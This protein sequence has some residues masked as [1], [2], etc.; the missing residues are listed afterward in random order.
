[1]LMT[2]PHWSLVE[3][4]RADA[5]TTPASAASGLLLPGQHAVAVGAGGGAQLE[6][7]VEAGRPGPRHEREQFRAEF[8]GRARTGC[9]ASTGHAISAAAPATPSAP[10]VSP[11][12]SNTARSAGTPA[13]SARRCSWAASASAGCPNG[14]PSST[15]PGPP[16]LAWRSAA[17]IASQFSFTS[18]APDTLTSLNTCGCLRISLAAIPSATSSIVYPVPS[19]RSDATSA[20]KYTCSR[21]SPSSSRTASGSPLSS[22]SIAS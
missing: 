12:T 2:C 1:M 5:L 8:A 20:W 21:T 18:S 17:L 7:G 13:R 22:A 16:D 19:V 11:G 6:L 3:R 9:A 14:T 4:Q 15:E 10:A